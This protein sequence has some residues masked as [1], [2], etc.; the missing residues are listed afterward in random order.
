MKNAKL[1]IGF[2]LL[3]CVI[4]LVGIILLGTMYVAKERNDYSVKKLE[5]KEDIVIREVSNSDELPIYP[6]RDPVYPLRRVET[7]FQ[8]VGTLVYK[9]ADEDAEPIILPLFG[10]PMPTRADRWEYY[11]ATD[12]QNM[13]KIPI[14]FERNDCLEE[15]GCREVYNRDKVFIPAYE[16]EF[17][18]NLYK[19]RT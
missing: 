10:R 15:V 3:F 7:P 12:K 9:R 2:L 19:Y 14:N 17:E 6:R 1:I 8:Q 16:K 13:L 18:V 11:T 5:K 4:L